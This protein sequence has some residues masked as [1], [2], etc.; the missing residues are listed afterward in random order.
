MM[1]GCAAL[2]GYI[3]E[4]DATVVTQILDAGGRISGKAACESL[5]MS[6]SSFT[7]SKGCI[8]NYH[9]RLHS[10][11]GSSG[12]SGTLV[13]S[14]DVDMAVG[15]DQGGSVRI[16]ASWCGIV[17]LKPTFGL[18]P[19][20]GAMSIDPSVDHLGPMARTVQDCAL[21]L[22][23]LAGYD[24]GLDP[25]QPPNI[26]T[27][28]YS[29]EMVVDNLNGTKVGLVSE[30]FGLPRSDPR[31]DEMVRNAV[32]KLK[33]AGAEVAEISIP[34][35]KYGGVIC[36]ALACE[37]TIDNLFN[38]GGGGTGH[39]GFYP[40][41]LMSFA[42]KSFRSSRVNDLSHV[43]KMVMLSAEYIKQNY[44]GQWY[45]KA[46]NLRRLLTSEYETAFKKFD[47]VAMPTVPFTAPKLPN[48]DA[49]VFDLLTV[50]NNMADNLC[51]ADL[52]GIPALSINVGFI[53]GLPVGAHFEAAAF[54]EVKL[55]QV[56]GILEKLV[57]DTA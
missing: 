7:Y 40:T 50:S 54:E 19:Y 32:L 47:I 27:F 28:E 23:V 35:V 41:S 4:F 37:G 14:G 26:Q 10:A 6:G 55:L 17:G 31:V 12:G 56:G 36:E 3:P 49:S 42:A 29:K 13:A 11:G 38:C 5:C 45:G 53:D 57:K 15:G 25:R 52:T 22:E 44:P 20:T 1:H 8:L 21:L 48:K 16:P 33:T 34:L 9:N 2:E 46:Q 43:T 30:G 18:V 51:P 39:K 24:N